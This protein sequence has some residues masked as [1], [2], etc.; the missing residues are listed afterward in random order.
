MTIIEVDSINVQPLTVDEI[1]IFAGQR[2]SFVLN[3]NQPIGNYWIRS[4]PNLGATTFDGGL[5]SAILRYWGAPNADPTTTSTVSNPLIETNLHPLVA[6]P[7]PGIATPGAADVNIALNIGFDFPSLHFLV[8]GAPFIPPTDPVLLQILGGAHTPQD[9][10]PAGSVYV[11]PPNK[12]IELSF[13]MTAA[14]VGAPHPIHLHGHAF[15][16]VR[17]AGSTAYNFLNSVERD[18]VSA[19]S[20][21]DN[22]TIRFTTDNPGPWIMHCHIDWHLEAGLSVVFAEDVA[23]ISTSTQPPAWDQ[24]CPTYN[25]LPPQTFPPP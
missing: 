11:L 2:Y 3:T 14:A 16:V 23:S 21:G 9:L 17:S 19:G 22:V 15:H 1:Q 4:K 6:S 24:L 7:A 12:V 18:V 5:N 8:N 25:A 10:L 13:P 20:P